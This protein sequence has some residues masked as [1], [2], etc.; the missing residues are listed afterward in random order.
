[1]N[2]FERQKRARNLHKRGLSLR[3][4]AAELGC[5]HMTVS[6]DINGRSDRRG[7]SAVVEVSL[8]PDP[9]VSPEPS[10]GVQEDVQNVHTKNGQGPARVKASLRDVDGVMLHIDQLYSLCLASAKRGN[11]RAL[12]LASSLLNKRIDLLDAPRF[13]QGHV[14]SIE[15]ERQLLDL[16]EV[17]RRHLFGNFTRVIAQRFDVDE[18]ALE[19]TLRE[20]ADGVQQELNFRQGITD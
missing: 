11:H 14:E 12:A 16:F 17:W 18:M 8:E 10:N 5:G 4:I 13:C 3:D 6:R 7:P 2:R 19:E 1:M 20:L 9:S 15:A